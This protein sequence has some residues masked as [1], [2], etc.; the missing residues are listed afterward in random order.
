MPVILLIKAVDHTHPNTDKNKACYKRGDIIEAYASDHT[1]G[2]KEG[3]P[4]HYKITIT[5][6]TPVNVSQYCFPQMDGET[7]VTIRQYAINIDG[8]P[9]EDKS[10]LESTGELSKTSSY[11]LTYLENKAS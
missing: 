10:T 7:L 8:L 3:L 1:I 4:Y 5:N 6:I 9:S 2:S 11:L